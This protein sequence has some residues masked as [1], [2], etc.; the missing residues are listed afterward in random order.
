MEVAIA[1]TDFMTEKISH[2]VAHA[3]IHVKPVL[4]EA[5]QQTVLIALFSQVGN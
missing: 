3:I 4:K 1:V 5:I 2:L